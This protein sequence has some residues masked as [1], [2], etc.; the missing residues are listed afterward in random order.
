MI[1]NWKLFIENLEADSDD[2]IKKSINVIQ[3]DSRQRTVNLVKVD[4]WTYNKIT[5][6]I[7]HGCRIFTSV[8]YYP[9]EDTLYTDDE[10]LIREF[11]TEVDDKGMYN[12][13]DC[14]FILIPYSKEYPLWGNAVIVGADDDGESDNVKSILNNI[15]KDIVFIDKS[16]GIKAWRWDGEKYKQFR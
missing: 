6:L 15:R 11:D 16:E 7:G 14:G 10:F 2:E 3:I 12:P 1:Q 4:N 9:N 8:Y 13:A 5:E